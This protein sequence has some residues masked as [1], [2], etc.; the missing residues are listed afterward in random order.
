MFW[1]RRILAAA[2]LA[3]ACA[4]IAPSGAQAQSGPPAGRYECWFNGRPVLILNFTLLG[5]G[6][7]ADVDNKPGS[8]SY[9]AGS[10]VLRFSG[11]SL[12]GQR[13]VF[14]PGRTP[15]VYFIGPSGTENENCDFAG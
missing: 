15:A 11:G 5:G 6:R 4:G 13:G 2:A 9:D 10:R 12:D 3:A 1:S 7:Y 14:H 8:Y